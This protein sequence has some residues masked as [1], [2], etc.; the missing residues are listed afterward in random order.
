ML[1]S[2]LVLG[3]GFLAA[4]S[5]NCVVDSVLQKTII[6]VL[7]PRRDFW[8]FGLDDSLHGLC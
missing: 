1:D 8:I 7:D 5:G 2:Q 6:E 3:S 4:H